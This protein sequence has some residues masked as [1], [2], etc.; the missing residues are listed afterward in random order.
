MAYKKEP[1]IKLKKCLVD[2]GPMQIKHVWTK[3]K[4]LRGEFEKYNYQLYTNYN[5]AENSLLDFFVKQHDQQRFT[6][7]T[8]PLVLGDFATEFAAVNPSVDD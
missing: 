2:K 4:N 8:N 7:M 6:N 5:N 1:L 3:G